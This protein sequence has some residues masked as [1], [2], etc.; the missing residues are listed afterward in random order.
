MKRQMRICIHPAVYHK[1]SNRIRKTIDT[2]VVMIAKGR[3]K[4]GNFGNQGNS[5]MTSLNVVGR[6]LIY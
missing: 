4:S 2:V 6:L 3:V 5:S 1:Y